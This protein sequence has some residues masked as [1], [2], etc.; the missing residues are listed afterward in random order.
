LSHLKDVGIGFVE[1]ATME[2]RLRRTRI[3]F[4]DPPFS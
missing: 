4:V 1:P 2:H 3:G